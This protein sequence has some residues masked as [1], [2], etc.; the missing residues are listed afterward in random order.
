[1]DMLKSYFKVGIRNI[2][3]NKVTSSINI[4]GLSLAISFALVC[5]A[6][7]NFTYTADRYHTNYE[8]IFMVENEINRD[9][10]SQL[11][12][13]SP[14]AIGP[15]MQ[16]DF[17][18]VEAYGRLRRS[19]A[20]MKYENEVFQQSIWYSDPGFMEMFDYQVKWGE[21]NSLKDPKNIIISEA[22][23][24]KYFANRNPIGEQMTMVFTGKDG[25]EVKES[26]FV[27]AVLEKFHW[28][29]SFTFDVL[30]HYDVRNRLGF[31]D[32]ISNWERFA[33]ATFILT[34]SAGDKSSLEAQMASYIPTQNESNEDFMISE[35]QLEPLATLCRNSYKL[36]SS[37]AMGGHAGGRIV[38]AAIAILL[39]MLACFNYMNISLSSA[40][41]RL[42][43]IGI[44]KAIGSRRNQLIYQFLSENILLCALALALG[45]VIAQFLIVPIFS[46]MLPVE[47]RLDVQNEWQVWVFLVGLVSL[48]AIGGG[49]YPAFYISKFKPGVILQG[50]QKFGKSS[51]FSKVILTIQYT[52]ALLTMG[53]SAVLIQ[54]SAYMQSLDLGYNDKN[55]IVV[56]VGEYYEEYR[57]AVSEYSN[58]VAFA[59]AQNPIAFSSPTIVIQK[60]TSKIEVEHLSVGANY[61]QTME[62]ELLDGRLFNAGITSDTIDAVVVNETFVQRLDIENPIGYTFKK[63]GKAYY[64]IGVVEDFHYEI[65]FFAIKPIIIS[66]A[67][68][69]TNFIARV[70]DGTEIEAMEHLKNVW[71]TIDPDTPFT[72]NLQES[73]FESFNTEMKG[74]S[75][76]GMII[77]IFAMIISCVG[78]FGIISLN[79]SKRLKEFSI[80]KVLG[81]SMQQ[82]S[83]MINK[84]VILILLLGIAIATPLGY[85]ASKSM[86][87]G[88]FA[89]HVPVTFVPF[90]VSGLALILTSL[91]TIS[92]KIY[93]VA[94]VN[95][96][97]NLRNE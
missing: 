47:L 55:A 42:K 89:Y 20:V 25:Q 54:N 43:E 69:L 78:L 15:A 10:D 8:R 35:F 13:I 70:T 9:G 33:S 60:D 88:I 71:Y 26:F 21:K 52:I 83:L 17:P 18:S 34:K 22:I 4:I 12:G 48:T 28:K 37:I 45:F 38:L 14:E 50:T 75:R 23:S 36:R 85:L 63:E 58:I 30:V 65:P 84:D 82:V 61:L 1:M 72:G 53:V 64:V 44:R 5:Y 57:D 79:I 80:R 92:S 51:R 73:S 74:E 81:A 94:T 19:S 6:F 56:P 46:E 11:W 90:I 16:A 86:M 67:P 7:L 32:N 87:E 2:Y 59:G 40:S 76:I 77:A 68:V 97:D 49:A 31:E 24:E 91:I 93:Q 96:V 62:V 41:K 3:K 39:L 95:P 27:G 29:S 66:Q